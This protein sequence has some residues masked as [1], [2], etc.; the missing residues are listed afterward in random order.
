MSRVGTTK[1]RRWQRWKQTFERQDKK[2]IISE[3]SVHSNYE[4]GFLYTSYVLDISIAK[5]VK[6][7][8]LY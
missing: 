5:R 2:K 6:T 7:A 3:N 8:C 1:S 4:R